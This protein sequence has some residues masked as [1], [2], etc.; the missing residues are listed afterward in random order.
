MVTAGA[1]A[2]PERDAAGRSGH[3]LRRDVQGLRAVAVLAVIGDH[4]LGRPAGGFVGVD[5]FFV[6]SGYLITGLLLREHARTGTISFRG[7]YARRV[8]RILPNAALTLAATVVAT[9]VLVGGARFVETVKDAVWAALCVVNWRFAAQGT[10]YFQEGLPPSPLQHFWS[11]AVEE[12]FY[13][14]WP[15][16]MVALIALAVR[17]GRGRH[18]SLVLG[19]AM[20]VV[21]LASLAW[22]LAQTDAAPTYAFF[23]T[24]TR[25]WE[26]G[27]G[28]LVAIGGSALAARLGRAR[29]ALAWV[30]LAGI[31]VALVVVRPE[32]GF[33]AP[34]ALL[35]V[36]STALVIVAGDGAK[37]P[38]LLTNRPATY[39]GDLSY[40]LY[41][42]HWPVV[43]L[44]PA[45][46]APTSSWFAPV[47]LVLGVGAAVLAFYLVEDPVRRLGARPATGAAAAHPRATGRTLVRAGVASLAAV[48][49]VAVGCTTAVWALERR[50]GGAPEDASAVGAQAECHG[51]ASLADPE[52]CA[53][54]VFSGA[55]QPPAA[56]AAD[57]TDDAYACYAPEG[58]PLKPC[59]LGVE[60]G[61]RVALV[62]NSHAAMLLPALRPHL[63]ELGWQLDVMTGNGC[64]VLSG[65]PGNCSGAM[66]ELR[67]RLL[68]GEPYELVVTTT[69]RSAAGADNPD[70]PQ[71]FAEGLAPVLDRSTVVAVSDGPI[72]SEGALAC[73]AR[74][75]ADVTTCGMDLDAAFAVP[76]PL[77]GAAAIDPRIRYLDVQDLYCSDERCAV[78]IGNVQAYRDT[79]GHI[80]GTYG[81]SLGPYLTERIEAAAAQP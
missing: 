31:G 18:R 76:D 7:F 58:E 49:V 52:A 43:V 62:G 77:E 38:W 68:D 22:A 1:V 48:A 47:A 42:W 15:W 2:A 53:D 27:V 39:V 28:A 34:W 32:A 25:V 72:V 23:S 35:P 50:A 46:L 81:R 67:S 73:V 66:P 63:E 6:I 30:G 51:A 45:L 59:T 21:V 3:T 65:D 10:D 11:L 78:V 61:T 24:A 12:Q 54:V 20:T 57:D 13:F 70:L 17:R 4:V 79:A 26:L 41:L 44:L 29:P 14:V 33:P 8:R 74:V 16:L 55:V 9:A 40:S 19:A 71:R 75:G 80:T 56:D 37:G 36:L 69:S 60:G 5:V 64:N